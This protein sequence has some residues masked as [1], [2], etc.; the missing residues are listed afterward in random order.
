MKKT[1]IYTLMIVLA[2]FSCQQ[3]GT[4]VAMP[5]AEEAKSETAAGKFGAVSMDSGVVTL[6]EVV[7]E[8]RTNSK[9]KLSVKSKKSAPK[10]D[11]G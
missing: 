10:K 11:V 5:A 4:E 9:A 7:S 6:A 3:K 2:G 8:L 1:F